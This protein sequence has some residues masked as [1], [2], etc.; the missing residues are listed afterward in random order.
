MDVWMVILLVYVCIAAGRWSYLY[1]SY[2]YFNGGRMPILTF[3]R[4]VVWFSPWGLKYRTNH[5]RKIVENNDRG[6]IGIW[7]INEIRQNNLYETVAKKFF[8][9][10]KTFW[11]LY[12]LVPLF[13]FIPSSVIIKKLLPQ[14]C[15]FP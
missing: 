6:S 15:C 10:P 8:G 12:V 3:F 4:D 14:E 13:W 9:K 5:V 2:V 7:D 11:I 1:S